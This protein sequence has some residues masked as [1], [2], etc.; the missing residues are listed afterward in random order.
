MLA[1]FMWL[2]LS[3]FTPLTAAECSVASIVALTAFW[4]LTEAFPL[5][6]SAMVP[7]I[8]FPAADILTYKEASSAFGSHV[9]MLL[10]ASFMF[11]R[12]LEKS[13]VHERIARLLVRA[14]GCTGKRLVFGFMITGAILSMWISNTASTLILVPIAIAVLG[15][16]HNRNL[17]IAL[18]LG[19]AYSC[20]IG[21]VGTLVGTPPNLIFAS[22]YSELTGE[23]FLFLDWMKTGL[24]SVLLSIPLMALWMSRKID[25]SLRVEIDPPGPW[26]WP[27]VIT[28]TVFLLAVLGWVT[29]TA[30]FGGWGA[31]LDM[32]NVG[33]V[34]VVMSAVL[35][36]F[37]IPT[38]KGDRVLD[39]KTASSIPWGLLI[40][41]ASGICI[42]NAFVA[43]GLS[44]RIGGGLQGIEE[45][46]PFLMMFA[47]IISVSMMT[48]MASSTATA[49]LVLPVLAAVASG[50]DMAPELLM[51]PAALG[52]SCSFMLPVA[53][54]PNA[55]VMTTGRLRV[56]DM[57]REG[58]ALNFI[59]AIALTIASWLTL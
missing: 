39:W 15:K 23:E 47:V 51:V 55:I 18:L 3:F 7:F 29:R 8:L 19:I 34:T 13:G 1:I 9:I 53:T 36:M 43:S 35:L 22:L 57:A 41:F 38:G 33:D 48:E 21:G 32:S 46:H 26:R 44:V 4:W 37:L 17:E 25:S 40:L 27:E 42:A 56:L 28:L 12:A 10:M 20:S 50:A 54:A 58:L 24:L 5:P 30:P 31:L 49:T 11:T 16:M 6:V 59:V 52:A 14:V 2:M 45:L